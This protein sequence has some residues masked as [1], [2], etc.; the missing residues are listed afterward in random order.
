MDHLI[1]RLRAAL[2]AAGIPATEADFAGI[3]EKGFLSRF[4]DIERL[5]DAVDHEQLPDMLDAVNLPPAASPPNG[6]LPTS[7]DPTS[8]FGIATQLQRKTISP[9]ELVEQALERIADYDA[10]L[11]VFQIV[12]AE[13]ALADART[14]AAELAAGKIRSPLH[15]VP[16]AVKDLF[17]VAGYPTAAGS[18]IRAGVMAATDATVVE[19]L[20]AAGAIV[21]GKTRMS[22]FA[23][24][25]GSN[26][27]HYGPTANPYD[28]SR[29]S[30]GSSSGS[31]VAVATGMAFAA[32][33]TDT[34]GSIRIPAAHCGIV[35]L[36]P[37][38]GRVSLA[39]GFPLSWSL[40]HAGPMTRAV[41]DTA[42]LL[43][44]IGG[45]DPRD[46]RTLRLAPD[47]TIGGITA[48]A[49]NLRVGLLTADGSGQPL[50]GVDELTAM[51]RAADA[52]DGQGAII[53]PIDVPELEELRLLNP[54]LLA[55]EAAA[56][57]LPWLR[58][59][60]DDYGEFMRH[61]ILA[62]FIYSPVDAARIQQAR[63]ML[64]RRVAERLAEIDLL[65]TPV[66]PASAPALGIP[67]PTS[68][69]GP[70][71]FLGWPAL[72]L[73][74]GYGSDGVPRAAQLIAR[75]WNEPLLLRAAYA[76]EQVLGRLAPSL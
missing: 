25:P 15:G 19:R 1:D 27:A 7:D 40:D 69:T 41:A 4:P 38:H 60:L 2:R 32:I 34:G 5:L 55:I 28:R 59:R 68:F 61:R 36:K 11:N 39:G 44:V 46:P 31:G 64:R 21:I 52:L 33:G 35:G 45:P 6:D 43:S 17:D 54:A 42:L 67:T 30:G 49:R 51:R 70:W 56:L 63:A 58:T 50:A 71:N 76:A 26:N 12:M 62:A 37:T 53:I 24:S 20:R 73:P 9:V 14:A 18:R 22:E 23:Y 8:I 29:D 57:H 47:V 3:I 66:V 72:S 13:S 16:V 10:E 48:G 75:P 74:T 65:I